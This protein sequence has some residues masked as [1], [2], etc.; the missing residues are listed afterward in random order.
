MFA[1]VFGILTS[2][3]AGAWIA[4][5]SQFGLAVSLGAKTLLILGYVGLGVLL[6]TITRAS[7]TGA[8]WGGFDLL[9]PTGATSRPVSG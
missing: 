6:G 9:H 1:L 2:A 4:A 7:V 3:V 5:E 8:V